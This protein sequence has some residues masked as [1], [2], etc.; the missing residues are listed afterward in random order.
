MIYLWVLCAN[1]NQ[2]MM[3][4]NKNFLVFLVIDEPMQTL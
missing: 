1:N 3:N 4:K 2:D